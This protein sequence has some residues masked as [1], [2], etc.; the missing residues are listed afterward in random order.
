MKKLIYIFTLVTFYLV[1]IFSQNPER[2][3]MWVHGL[4]GSNESWI[5]NAKH[6]K[7]KFF[8]NSMK[9]DY[10]KGPDA[11]GSSDIV[12]KQFELFFPRQGNNN[13]NIAVAH[14]FGG[15]VA[16][17][18]EKRNAEAGISQNFGGQILVHSPQ[19]GAEFAANF[20]NGLFDK[21]FVEMWDKLTKPFKHEDIDESAIIILSGTDIIPMNYFLK[22]YE[23]FF[24]IN[25]NDGERELEWFKEKLD[26]I[27]F[28]DEEKIDDLDPNSD[29]I[30]D[31]EEFDGPGEIISVWGGEEGNILDRLISSMMVKP[32]NKT[33]DIVSDENSILTKAASAYGSLGTINRA[34]G[35]AA[36]VTLTNLFSKA[37]SGHNTVYHERARIWNEGKDYLN[38]SAETD[39]LI[40]I[41]ANTWQPKQIKIKVKTDDCNNQYESYQNLMREYMNSGNFDKMDE[42]TRLMSE[43]EAN[44][45]CYYDKDITIQ[46]PVS[47]PND[48]VV[49]TESQKA[50]G[51]ILFENK[52][53][54]HFEALNTKVMS[55]NFTSIFRDGEKGSGW[56]KTQLR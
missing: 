23:L 43:L 22:I 51:G 9:A 56:F 5:T 55:D 32:G 48:G 31:L 52:N 10:P 19:S 18:L 47:L 40:M 2:N 33:L 30:K 24:G 6:H 35:I 4:G 8:M 54:N 36:D 29:I 11:N 16:R 53:C 39:W 14:S 20:K 41:G 7:E 26:I 21:K 50:A 27:D 25:N 46:V 3:V 1:N 44:P 15:I 28:Y 42:I 37:F 12:K 13:R 17:N 34:L 49:L 45:D 38:N